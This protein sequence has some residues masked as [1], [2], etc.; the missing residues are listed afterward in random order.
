MASNV[1]SE[2]QLTESLHSTQGGFAVYPRFILSGGGGRSASLG[3]KIKK[4]FRFVPF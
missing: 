2:R 3:A 1:N 4:I